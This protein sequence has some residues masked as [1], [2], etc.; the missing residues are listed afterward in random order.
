MLGYYLWSRCSAA[1]EQN[2]NLQ[3]RL[4]NLETAISR[5]LGLGH[6]HEVFRPQHRPPLPPNPAP[7]PKP[8]ASP[9]PTPVAPQTCVISP[10]PPKAPVVEDVPTATLVDVDSECDKIL[11][12]EGI[13]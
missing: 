3:V 8:V 7:V 2:K 12:E 9:V 1:E 11:R 13:H 10:P 5:I 4:E 6:P